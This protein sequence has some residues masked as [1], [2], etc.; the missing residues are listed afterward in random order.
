MQHKI[1]TKSGTERLEAYIDG[2]PYSLLCTYTT[3]NR[4][5]NTVY[6]KDNGSDVVI[7]Q[8]GKSAILGLFSIRQE[9][10]HMLLTYLDST[11]SEKHGFGYCLK[12]EL[13][14]YLSKASERGET[15]PRLLSALSAPSRSFFSY[16]RS[17]I[18]HIA[19]LAPK[20]RAQI[21][22]HTVSIVHTDAKPQTVPISI[23]QDVFFDREAPH[24]TPAQTLPEGWH[25]RKYY[26]GSGGLE[27]PYGKMYFLHSVTIDGEIGTFEYTETLDTPWRVFEG[28]EP[29]FRR[30]CEA[31]VSQRYLTRTAPL[32]AKIQT[33]ALRAG[34]PE[35]AEHKP[36]QLSTPA[37][38][39]ARC[40]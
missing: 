39:P 31:V 33:A 40:P 16:L 9:K 19:H 29:D 12:G 1:Q 28:A 10:I 22:Q 17:Y 23:G 34:A 11:I 37:T 30:E 4:S 27:A 3:K 36:K 35:P 38:D 24:I 32:D 18:P 21:Q 5:Q 25:W 15:Y 8:D 14:Q 26:D 7:E 13:E 2:E 6:I 20:L